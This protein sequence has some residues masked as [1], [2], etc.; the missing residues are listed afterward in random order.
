M[1]TLADNRAKAVLT[2]LLQLV[3]DKKI[4]AVEAWDCFSSPKA[5]YKFKKLTIKLQEKQV[6]SIN[7][8]REN[9][10]KRLRTQINKR[11]AYCKRVM[12]QHGM[13]WHIEHIYGKTKFPERMFLLSNLTYACIDCNMIKNNTV[14]RKNPFVFDIINPNAK[15]FKYGDHMKFL[16]LSTESIHLLKYAPCSAEGTNT[17]NKLKLSTI[18][19]LE[20]LSSLNESVRHMNDRIDERLG[21]LLFEGGHPEVADFLHSLKSNIAKN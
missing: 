18:E 10:Q 6:Y 2:R 14:D 8:L 12:G 21:E 16:Q 20:V 5:S 17:Y 4:S 3:T 15:N 9:V 19:H 1:I 13:S 11:C 7:S